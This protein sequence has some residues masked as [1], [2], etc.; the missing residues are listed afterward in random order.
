MTGGLSS[1]I[2]RRIR[3][4]MLYAWENVIKELVDIPVIITRQNQ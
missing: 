4:T 1:N 3:K 2:G